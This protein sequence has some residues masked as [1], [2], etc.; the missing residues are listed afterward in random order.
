[1]PTDYRLWIISAPAPKVA[2]PGASDAPFLHNLTRRE[3]LPLVLNPQ[4]VHYVKFATL[5]SRRCSDGGGAGG[6]RQILR[7]APRGSPH[8]AESN[9][10]ST[11]PAKPAKSRLNHKRVCFSRLSFRCFRHR[12]RFGGSPPPAE[13]NSASA[14]AAKPAKSRLN[15]KRVCF[16]RLS[17]RRLRHRIRFG[18]R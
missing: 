5:V 15:R 17:F 14:T 9:S 3:A 13:S 10:A 4:G 11:T 8:S 6:R 1:M 2:S 7:P 18:G 16:S 12:I